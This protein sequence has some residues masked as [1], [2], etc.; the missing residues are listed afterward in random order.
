MTLLVLQPEKTQDRM[1][2]F[3]LFRQIQSH[4]NEIWGVMWDFAYIWP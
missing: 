1:I 2:A 4:K 3:T